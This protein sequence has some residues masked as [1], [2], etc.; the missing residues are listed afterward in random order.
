ML[1]K[2]LVIAPHPDDETLGCGGALF[3][4]KEEGDSVHWLICTEMRSDQGGVSTRIEQRK[5]EIEAVSEIFGFNGVYLLGFPTARLDQ[6]PIVDLVE[7]IGRVFHEVRPDV[8]YLPYGGDAHSDHKIVFN[9]AASCCKVFRHPSVR[10]VL[11]YETLSETDFG[12][13]PDSSGFRPQVFVSIDQH[14]E[15]KIAALNLYAGEMQEFPF[16]RSEQAVRS[17]AALRGVMA[18]THAAEAFM[19][20]REI[21]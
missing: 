7:A 20:L 5:K 9:S 3:R 18:G 4:H 12:L 15:K 13:N 17:L 16:P 21:V 11:V 10:K 8:V 2:I 14:L 19:L 1:K 6:V